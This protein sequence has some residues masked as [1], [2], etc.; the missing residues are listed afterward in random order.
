MAPSSFGVYCSCT[1]MFLE[2]EFSLSATLEFACT[3]SIFSYLKIGVKCRQALFS[4]ASTRAACC[5]VGRCPTV[6]LCLQ[7][8]LVWLLSV[9]KWRSWP[10]YQHSDKQHSCPVDLSGI[11]VRLVILA[12][13]SIWLL[14]CP[15]RNKANAV[16]AVN[17]TLLL[18][19]WNRF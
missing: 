11:V 9:K 17:A 3:V 19:H 1:P 4:T 13:T 12:P 8:L 18:G 15:E 6:K 16:S 14:S 5:K 2:S 10:S 7:Q